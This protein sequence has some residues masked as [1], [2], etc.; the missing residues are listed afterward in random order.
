MLQPLTKPCD[1]FSD[2]IPGAHK[3]VWK[4]KKNPTPQAPQRTRNLMAHED[5]NMKTAKAPSQSRTLAGRL[6][7]PT[8]HSSLSPSSA[9]SGKHSRC[10]QFNISLPDALV[11]SRQLQLDA[12]LV[13]QQVLLFSQ[14][15]LKDKLNKRTYSSQA[16]GSQLPSHP[17]DSQYRIKATIALA[18]T[19]S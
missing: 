18:Q 14:I 3:K 12:L 9:C 13:H 6:L 4:E 17:T 8:G 7:A 16:T 15:L 11:S 1:R 19:Y 5:I 10:F 2:Q